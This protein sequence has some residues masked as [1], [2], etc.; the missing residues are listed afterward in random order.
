MCLQR[1]S[2]HAC[3]CVQPHVPG[4]LIGGT[5]VPVCRPNKECFPERSPTGSPPVGPLNTI[6][7]S[8]LGIQ[9]ANWQTVSPEGWRPKKSNAADAIITSQMR[10]EEK[11]KFRKMWQWLDDNWLRQQL[12]PETNN[13]R[14]VLP[15][16]MTLPSPVSRADQRGLGR[17]MFAPREDPVDRTI[18]FAKK[19]RPPPPPTLAAAVFSK[20]VKKAV[21]QGKRRLN[22]E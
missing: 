2:S 12:V 16:G 6:H 8:R 14:L 20:H 18:R 21:N 9:A 7:N 17:S 5:F 1:K 13:R 4:M 10:H 19:R 3:V 22:K 11:R 15:N